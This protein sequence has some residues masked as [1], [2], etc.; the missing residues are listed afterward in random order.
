VSLDASF[1]NVKKWKEIQKEKGKLIVGKLT[2][3]MMRFPV[4][5]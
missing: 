3:Q 2:Q 1:N 4:E 5:W